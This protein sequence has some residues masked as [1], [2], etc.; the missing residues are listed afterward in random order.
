MTAAVLLRAAR[1]TSEYLE[2]WEIIDYASVTKPVVPSGTARELAEPLGAV[3]TSEPGVS[4]AEPLR[5]VRTPEPGWR[6]AETLGASGRPSREF[7]WLVP[8]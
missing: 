6:L 1:H 5:A 3:R 7:L 8:E 4:L 2:H